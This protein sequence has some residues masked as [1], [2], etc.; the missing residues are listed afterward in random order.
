[1]NP[2]HTVNH[3]TPQV[4]PSPSRLT[5]VG[6]LQAA[7]GLAALAA[8]PVAWGEDRISTDRPDF[9]ESSLVVGK[10]RF[11]I[12]TSFSLERNRDAD[13]RTRVST[14]PTLLRYGI[15][16]EWE[17][18]IET[19]GATHL[20]E[21]GTWGTQRVS[22][23]SDID[24]GSKWHMQDGDEAS[25]K[26]SVAWLFHTTLPSGSKGN[27][28][29]GVRPSVR[30][31]AEWELPQDWAVGVMPGVNY[32]T[33]DDGKRFVSAIAAITVAKSWTENFRTY[34]E[35]AGQQLTS[36]RNGG[37]VV[38]YDVGAA[39]LIGNDMQ[40]DIS[41]AWRATKQAPEFSWGVGLSVRF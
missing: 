21:S 28:G 38:T 27:R 37:N 16:K 30:M 7:C 11:Q 34:W 18:R 14:T 29:K 22:G 2:I 24:V 6:L 17:I 10:G 25:G 31:V 35:I 33:R 15:S 26:P 3:M 19:D 1:M 32:D 23:T 4:P 20:Q 36:E 41:G 9:V 39:Y 8:V 13:L 12:E 5:R 40:L